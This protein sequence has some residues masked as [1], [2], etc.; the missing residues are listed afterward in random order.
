VRRL[1]VTANVSRTP[2]LV[3]L[4][5]EALS[6]SET[7]VLTRATRNNIPEDSILRTRHNLDIIASPFGIGLFSHV[8]RLCDTVKGNETSSL[9]SG[10]V[11]RLTN[12]RT[13]WTLVPKRTTPTERPP[14]VDEI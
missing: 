10:L 13:L 12:K 8:Q 14:L 6:S 2:I 5:M 1:I 3:T 7:S 11:C 4:M 9:H